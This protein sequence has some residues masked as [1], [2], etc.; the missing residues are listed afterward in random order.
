MVAPPGQLTPGI[1]RCPLQCAPLVSLSILTPFIYNKHEALF[2]HTVSHL[3]LKRNQTAARSARHRPI[4]RR[5]IPSHA[6]ER[7]KG[8]RLIDFSHS[9]S[10]A[11][12]LYKVGRNN[13]AM[14]YKR[15]SVLWPL[16]TSHGA[17]PAFHRFASCFGQKSYICL[18]GRKRFQL[19]LFCCDS[20]VNDD[21][22]IY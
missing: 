16:A 15:A 8:C 7:P 12:S 20:H 10:L 9:H 18:T 3:Y 5:L 13:T 17:C 21:G 22:W 19:Q 2:K 11:L 1:N 4:F 6:T 14:K